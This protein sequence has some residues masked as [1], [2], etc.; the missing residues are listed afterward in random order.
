[1]AVSKRKNFSYCWSGVGLNIDIMDRGRRVPSEPDQH[2]PHY[3]SYLMSSG[4]CAA[5]TEHFRAEPGN[6]L[7]ITITK[8]DISPLPAGELIIQP[9]WD[10]QKD[11]IVGVMLDEDIWQLVRILV[12]SGGVLVVPSAILL[13]RRFHK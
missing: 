10:N 12:V 11:K 2:P 4:P 5:Y 7:A 6:S 9:A 13:F 8:S 3:P 1:M